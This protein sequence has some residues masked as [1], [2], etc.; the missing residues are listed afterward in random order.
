[1]HAQPELVSDMEINGIV[2]FLY[3]QNGDPEY[4][5]DIHA[6]VKMLKRVRLNLIMKTHKTT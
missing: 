2:D 4:A 5:M 1:L 3:D 6:S